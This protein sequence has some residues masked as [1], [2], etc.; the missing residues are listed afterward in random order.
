MLRDGIPHGIWFASYEYAKTELSHH[1]SRTNETTQDG[2]V[3]PMIAGAFAATTAWA[4]G[5]P[6]DLIKTRIQASYGKKGVWATAIDIVNE[7]GRQGLYKGFTLKLF[8]A[9][10]ASVIG[11]LTYEMAV[12]HLTPSS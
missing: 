2:I 8:R 12:K 10:P 6:F 11:F 9:I 3:T 7:S 1:R 5:Y 4:V